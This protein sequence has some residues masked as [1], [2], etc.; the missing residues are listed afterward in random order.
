MAIYLVISRT[1][2]QMEFH[3]DINQ[4]NIITIISHRINMIRFKRVGIVFD[5]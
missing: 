5:E 2:R 1:N 4:F 3:N